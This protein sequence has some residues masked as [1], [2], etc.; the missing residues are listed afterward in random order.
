MCDF[1]RSQQSDIIKH[2]SGLPLQFTLE[3]KSAVIVSLMELAKEDGN[4]SVRRLGYLEQLLDL[5]NIE[6]NSYAFKKVYTEG[7]EQS[8]NRL[9]KLWGNQKEWYVIMLYGLL[10]SD[11]P[12]MLSACKKIGIGKQQYEQII[13]AYINYN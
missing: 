8:L 4:V 10:G 7:R 13:A 3:Q 1:K 11:Q 9:K 5:L 6:E 12:E 2:L